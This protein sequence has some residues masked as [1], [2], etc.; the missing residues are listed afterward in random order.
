MTYD[1]KLA[2]FIL[3]EVITGHDWRNHVKECDICLNWVI[4]ADRDPYRLKCGE[5]WILQDMVRLATER[6][7]NPSHF[8]A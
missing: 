6:V 1:E 4:S 2:D 3:D 8:I 7:E 5:G